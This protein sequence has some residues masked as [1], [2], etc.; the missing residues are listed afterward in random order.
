MK[1]HPIMLMFQRPMLR[2]M[3]AVAGFASLFAV[4]LPAQTP[5]RRLAAVPAATESRV[6]LPGDGGNRHHDH[7]AL[8]GALQGETALTSMALVLK[9]TDA[10]DAALTQ[11]LADQANPA[12]SSYRQ[13]LTP[14]Q[15]GAR[16]GVADADLAILE[17]WL[18]SRGLTVNAVA[19][20]HN[21]ITFSGTASAVENAFSV[22]MKRYTRGNQT[23]FENADAVQLPASLAAVVGGVTGLSSYRLPA[24]Q[25]KRV[26]VAQ[27]TTASPDYTTATGTH[28]IVPW[29]FRQMFGINTLISSGYT[30]SGIKIGVIGQSAV[31]TTQLT[32]FQQKTGQTVSLPTMVLV[33]NT[34]ASAKVAGDE[35]ESEL[36]LEYA[37]GSAPGASIQFIYTGC[38]NATTENCNN[39][40]VFD[41]LSY[42]IT[43]DL[44][45]ILTLSY[46][47]CEA[48][49][50][51]YATST[52]E[53][54]LRQA[55]SQGQTVL[56][57]SG[58]AGAASCETSDTPKT[59]TAGL[60]VS[61]PASSIYVTAVGGT[62]LNSDSS[63]YW[64]S[65][66]NSSLGSAI[67]YVPEIAWNDTAAYGSLTA[68]GGGFS[69]IFGKPSWQ[70]GTGVPSDG[71]RDV[72]DVAFPAN[73]SEH[74]YLICDAY[75][76]CISG[77]QSFTLTATGRDGGGVGGTSASAPNFAA[78]LAVI[79]Q[80]NGGKSLGNINPSLY[81]LAAGTTG[82]SIFHDIISGSN[83]VPCTIGTTDCTTGSMGYSTTTGYDEV[84][85]LGSIAAPALLTGIQSTTATAKQTP[86]VG[87]TAS[88][89]TPTLNTSL[90]FA[91]TVTNGT[92]TAPTGTVTF[93]VD[94]TVAGT[95]V[96]LVSG[97]ASYTQS[98][99]FTTTG[100]HTITA[101]YSGDG[102][103]LAA[104][105]T[106]TITVSST[107]TSSSGGISMSSLP[108]T[109][110]IASGS[111]GTE[112]ITIV[113]GGFAGPLTFRA[114]LTSATSSTFPYCLSITPVT[115]AANATQ[116]ATL[117]VNT[118]S[119]C[120]TTGGIPVSSAAVPTVPKVGGIA[121]DHR[122][123]ALA[124][125][126]GGVLALFGLRRR[127]FRAALFVLAAAVLTLGI[128]SCG[129]GG[130]TTTTTTTTGGG[131]TTTTTT[132]VTGTY[133]LQISA[134][135]SSNTTI[136]ASTTFTLVVK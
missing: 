64:S 59:A 67:G 66:N 98:A 74:A 125:L 16:F 94:G 22:E 4:L 106:L 56:V 78:M 124:A 75:D 47:G 120:S 93:A 81:T 7:A 76:P 39:D 13:W 117:T 24:P 84:T 129:G 134:Y 8:Q 12:S 17:S 114:A 61:Y 100:S 23:F 60:S 130:S 122:G 45:P 5:V 29:D 6:A 77:T 28:Y 52:L 79:E 57:S 14:T 43:S 25:Q 97:A 9:P 92:T 19:T 71:H 91:V 32:Y 36:D 133:G 10:Q 40:G 68:S 87:L 107:A 102:N 110:T 11:L 62:T 3:P 50:A 109:L 86:T 112:A 54:L 44:A 111:S 20:S 21:R 116:T 95:A 55:N 96:T 34:S 58:D 121:S 33:P 1:V 27:A 49:D 105:N 70:A 63:T 26:A 35:E 115:L 119:T 126:S 132:G 41:A 99:G 136:S 73:V 127:K 89:D 90:T 51:S 80:A 135:S 31:D 48:E 2:I 123:I 53:P 38:A 128:T 88:N 101:S 18:Q 82:S 108:A 15:Y 30:G 104:S 118:V 37:S 69:K 113:S 85:G 65:T 103:N 46:G 131:G 72:P 42:A 83:I